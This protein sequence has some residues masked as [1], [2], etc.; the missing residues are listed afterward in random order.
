MAAQIAKNVKRSIIA[1]ILLLVSPGCD[2]DPLPTAMP[3][4][5]SAD[6]EITFVTRSADTARTRVASITYVVGASRGESSR[7]IDGQLVERSDHRTIEVK[8]EKLYQ[9]TRANR[10]DRVR[11]RRERGERV[12]WY[13]FTLKWPARA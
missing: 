10:I 6:F 13:T 7:V 3:Q 12:L 8:L 11:T 4:R 9:V 5:R 1:V 2:S